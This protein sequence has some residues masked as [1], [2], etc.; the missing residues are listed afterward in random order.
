M[1]FP[2]GTFLFC[3]R[4]DRGRD[5][6]DAAFAK[7]STTLKIAWLAFMQYVFL[8]WRKKGEQSVIDKEDNE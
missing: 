1:P 5:R 6:C 3:T 7:H 4:T 8:S 2:I